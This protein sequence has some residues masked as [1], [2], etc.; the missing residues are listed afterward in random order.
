M[1]YI[2]NLLTLRELPGIGERTLA[3]LLQTAANRSETPGD[4][5]AASRRHLA[6]AYG[7]PLAAIVRLHD[8]RRRHIERCRTILDELRR[9]RARILTQKCGEYPARLLRNGS[10]APPLLFALGNSA[11]ADAPCVAVLGSRE[12]TDHT[13][14]AIFAVVR[15]AHADGMSIA[16]GGMKST[17]R[18]AAICTRAVAAPRIVVLD[19]G[20]FSAFAFD[21][22]RDPF[23]CGDRPA[24]LDRSLT[25]V[26]S[27]FRP[28][29][30]AAPN[31]GRR[32]DRLVADLGDILF[33]SHARPGGE[34]DRICKNALA[35]GQA[36]LLWDTGNPDLLR[37]GARLTDAGLLA[38]GFRR[39]L[40]PSTRRYASPVPTL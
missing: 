6:E 35:R 19:R 18:L 13:L 15:S 40:A 10:D 37:A 33:A 7:M 11:I 4:I 16:I 23:G 22:D 36:V 39:L 1:A 14:S 9:A 21:Y 8:Q 20:L 27:P 30:H 32:R 31:S 3:K 17:H 24:Q 12:I 5:V 29:D 25:L 34:T 28:H 26:L 2:D 38:G